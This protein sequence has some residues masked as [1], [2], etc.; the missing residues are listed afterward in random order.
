M[1]SPLEL[2]NAHGGGVSV[3]VVMPEVRKP[4]GVGGR[5]FET[6]AARS[7]RSG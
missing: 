7:A 5:A 2:A 3:G 6:R 4:V 1:D